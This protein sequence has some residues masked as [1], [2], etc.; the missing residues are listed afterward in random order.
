VGEILGT[1]VGLRRL[2]VAFDLDQSRPVGEI[3]VNR[4]QRTVF[5][6]FR[7]SLVLGLVVRSH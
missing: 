6:G 7:E 2:R 3:G 4:A 1:M 5:D